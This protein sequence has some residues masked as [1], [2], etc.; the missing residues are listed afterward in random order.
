[1]LGLF[2]CRKSRS[3][4]YK[5]ILKQIVI[6]LLKITIIKNFSLKTI[7]LSFSCYLF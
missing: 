5:L 1:M 6:S 3:N 7:D 2:Y 4:P